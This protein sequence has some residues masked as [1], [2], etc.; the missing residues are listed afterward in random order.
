[1]GNSERVIDKREVNIVCVGYV[2]RI[3]ERERE[4]DQRCVCVCV[5]GG[6]EER[7]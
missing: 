3:G 4:R 6:G 2:R 7:K 5:G 1:M